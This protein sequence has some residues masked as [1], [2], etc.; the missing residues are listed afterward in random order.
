MQR[1]LHWAH[2]GT[3]VAAIFQPPRHIIC[4]LSQ[5]HASPFPGVSSFAT[6]PDATVYTGPTAGRTD[7][8]NLRVLRGKYSRGEKLS[9]VTAYDYPSAV[10]VRPTVA[11]VGVLVLLQAICKP[12]SHHSSRA[13]NAVA[14]KMTPQDGPLRSSGK[15]WT[16]SIPYSRLPITSRPGTSHSIYGTIRHLYGMYDVCIRICRITYY[17]IV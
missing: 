6:K 1:V 2:T 3:H 4:P 7:K 13:C 15:W 5:N 10:H 8:V 9:M 16:S 14:Y 12:V 17:M 11:V